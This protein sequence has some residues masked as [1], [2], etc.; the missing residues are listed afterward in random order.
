MNEQIY[1]W[2]KMFEQTKWTN[3]QTMIER[4]KDWNIDWLIIK[5]SINQWLNQS[6]NQSSNKSMNE[7]YV[8]KKLMFEQTNDPTKKWKN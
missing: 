8:W 3:K 2:K 1:A 4:L 6:I 5:Q 7:Q